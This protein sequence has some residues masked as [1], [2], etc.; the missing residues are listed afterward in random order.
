M[1]RLI[2]STIAVMSMVIALGCS[3]RADLYEVYDLAWSGASFGNS[4][5][6]SGTMTLDL[7]L[8]QTRVVILII[9]RRYYEPDGQRYRC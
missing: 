5:M 9:S 6:A 2:S 1:R 8:S 3:A 4:A 7:A